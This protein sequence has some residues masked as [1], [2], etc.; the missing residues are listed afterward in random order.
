MTSPLRYGAMPF[1][2]ILG[3]SACEEGAL[4]DRSAAAIEPGA[5]TATASTTQDVEAPEVFAAEELALWD[6]R[7]SLG[8]VW[9]AHP[10]VTDPERVRIANTVTGETVEGAL[11]RREREAPGPRIQVSSEAAKALGL[12]AGQPT[13]LKLVALR[14]QTIEIEVPAPDPLDIP[15]GETAPIVAIDDAV[16]MAEDDLSGNPA[17]E[18]LGDVEFAVAEEPRKGFWGRFRDSLRNK[19]QA[20]TSAATIAAGA[21]LGTDLANALPAPEVETASIDPITAAAEAAIT[22]V[23]ATDPAAPGNA[24]IQVGLFGQESNAQGAAEKLRKSGILPTVM[25]TEVG[26]KSYWRVVVGPLATASDRSDVIETVRGLGFKDAY[27][28]SS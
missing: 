16:L 10:D 7:P 14:E 3:L 11:F 2:L 1:A 23:E 5:A 4:L 12:L 6:G 25:L 15:A 26:G 9:V 18:P 13:E 17:V 27:F 19:P 20:D 21:D 22:E 24:F 8:G 28:T